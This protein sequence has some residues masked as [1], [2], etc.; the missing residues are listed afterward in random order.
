MFGW[1]D[2]AVIRITANFHGNTGAKSIAERSIS[3]Y[4][5]VI[6]LYAKAGDPTE[7]L[8]QRFHRSLI[9]MLRFTDSNSHG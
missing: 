9:K 1:D 6:M 5:C 2:S 3:L 8:V 4:L 7:V